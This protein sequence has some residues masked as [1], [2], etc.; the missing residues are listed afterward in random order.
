MIPKNLDFAAAQ[1]LWISKLNLDPNDLK[2]IEMQLPHP[3]YAD[4]I[5]NSLQFKSTR[6]GEKYQLDSYAKIKDQSWPDC[7]SYQD[8]LKLPPHI[9]EE[10]RQVHGFDFSIYGEDHIDQERWDKFQNGLWPVWEL[11]RYKHVILDLKK[12]FKEKIVLDF[13]AHGGIIS[14]MALKMGAKFVHCTNVRD[15]YV[16]LAQKMLG[17]S[18]YKKQFKTFRAD[19]HDYEHNKKICNG[20]DT[21]LLYGIMYH[22]HDHCQILDSITAAGPDTI[23]IDTLVDNSIINSDKAVVTWSTESAEN[24]WN[25]WFENQQ[26]ITNGAPNFAW[27]KLYLSQ[28]NYQPVHYDKYYS[29]S[30]DTLSVPDAQRSIMVFERV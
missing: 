27:F 23:I 5:L 3:K 4:L 2:S 7:H 9:I 16:S 15:E 17:L 11:V 13:A 8:L 24:V 14:L 21:V 1:Q 12:Y 22:V 6:H 18:E 10:C 19:I 25:G 26:I 29:A 20:I 30:V 28:K